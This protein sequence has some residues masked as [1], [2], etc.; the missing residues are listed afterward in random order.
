MNTN[1]YIV[2]DDNE[3]FDAGFQ[4]Q[5][6]YDKEREAVL[7]EL[8]KYS[9]KRIIPT[10]L[11]CF[12][13]G[14]AGVHHFTNGRILRGI[15]YFFTVGLFGI[16]WIYDMIKIVCGKFKDGNGKYINDVKVIMLQ[17]KLEGIDRKYANM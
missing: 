10:F 9:Y 16:G 11:L 7:E 5:S 15:L 4:G 6:N 1:K 13:L 12:C 2:E 3:I 17:G 14:V 8:E